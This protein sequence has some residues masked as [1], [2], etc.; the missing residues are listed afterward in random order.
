MKNPLKFIAVRLESRYVVNIYD[1]VNPKISGE[2]S[3]SCLAAVRQRPAV[4]QI[5]PPVA[6]S[7][8]NRSSLVRDTVQALWAYIAG[9]SKQLLSASVVSQSLVDL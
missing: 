7:I 3:N 6:R 2:K 4:A 1:L 5:I 8:N 9:D